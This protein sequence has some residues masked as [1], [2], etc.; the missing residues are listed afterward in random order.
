MCLISK[1]KPQRTT[2]PIQVYKIVENSMGILCAP[3]QTYRYFDFPRISNNC[4]VTPFERFGQFEY[5]FGY[6]HAFLS[7]EAALEELN[8]LKLRPGSKVYQL[9]SGKIPVNTEYA[10]STDGLTVCSRIIIL[11]KDYEHVCGL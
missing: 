8:L 5:G 4:P 10:I 9:Y 3:F 11:N 2:E 7:K 6:I 1:N